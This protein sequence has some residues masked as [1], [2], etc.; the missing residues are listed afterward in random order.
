MSMVKCCQQMFDVDMPS[1]IIEKRL[2]KF[3]PA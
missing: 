1:V 3:E 2:V